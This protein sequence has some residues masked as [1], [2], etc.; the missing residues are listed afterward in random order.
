VLA[1]R[2]LAVAA[3]ALAFSHPFLRSPAEDVQ[4]GQARQVVLIVDASMSMR[5]VEGG[6]PLFAKAR[7]QA[8]DLL[9]SLEPGSSAGIIY[10][11]ARPRAALPAVSRNLAALHEDLAKAQP[12]AERGNPAAALALAERMLEGHGHVYVFSDFKRTAWASVVLDTYKGLAIYLRPV[13]HT[14]VD[15]VGIVAVEKSPTEPIESEAIELACTVFNSTPAK[16][17]E[18]VR[19][20]MEGVTQKAEVEL[21]PYSSGAATFN[22]SLPTAGC[23]AGRV[24]LPPDALNDDNTRSFKIRV[25]R[26]LKVLLVSDADRGDLGSA[27]FFVG[28]ALS[29]SDYA[30]T[31]I[32]VVRRHSQDVDRAS[33]ET[34][35]AFFVVTP[36][37]LAGDTV[38]IIARRVTDG[39]YLACFLDGPAAGQLVGAL[40]GASGGA[41]A[42]PFQLRRQ[43][44]T[45]READAFSR[46]QTM[47]GPLKV[48]GS[49]DQG[50]LAGLQFRRHYLTEITP[51]RKDEVLLEFADGSAA[52][53]ISP[54]GRGAVVFANF[55][56]APDGG[57]LAGSPLFPAM[58]HEI[59]RTLRTSITEEMNTPGN[60]WQIDVVEAKASGAEEKPY[61]VKSPDGGK[62]D[63]TVVSRGRTVRLAMPAASLTG[64]YP[65][66]RGE[67]QV[68]VGVVNVDPK[69]TDTR[70]LA[71]A[72]LVKA[73]SASGGG[74]VS[75]LDD[76]GQLMSAGRPT[77]LWHHMVA[78][79]GVCLFAEMLMLALW[80]RRPQRVADLRLEGRA[81]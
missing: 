57:N 7:A 80:R 19:L 50:D 58:L 12:T 66:M 52:L 71:L 67:E 42:P 3:I 32:T 73:E 8:A 1:V 28:A 81:R 4:P 5:A 70:P 61:E 9:R 6:I 30:A 23:Y 77:D 48:F 2:T 13:T 39:A 62:V 21:Q 72:D 24:T 56:I 33:L 17:L 25:R 35:D 47:R 69:E 46:P 53:A 36:A 55:P 37:T 14:A 59:V 43:V 18:T 64:H 40:G 60:P 26:S 51:A 16:R 27:A 76:E 78:I 68:D 34:A 65:V 15:N 54:A 10:L 74:S 41:I 20:E 11:G 29:P 75:V 31:G 49:S 45:G 22:F 63:A 38:E 44:A 79:A